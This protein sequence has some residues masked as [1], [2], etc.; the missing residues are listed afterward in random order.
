MRELLRYETRGILVSKTPVTLSD[1]VTL[2]LFDFKTEAWEDKPVLLFVA[3]WLSALSGWHEVLEEITPHYRV[4]YMESREKRSARLPKGPLPRFDIDRL[5]GDIGEVAAE[6]VPPGTPLYVAGSSLGSTA[7][8]RAMA[9][10]RLSPKGA[11]LISPVTAFAF[12]AWGNFIIRFLPPCFFTVI[13]YLI[14]WYL[15]NFRVDKK[16]EPEQARKYTRTVMDA[17]PIRLKANAGALNGYTLWADLPKVNTPVVVIGAASDK[18]HGVEEIT[19]M[20]TGMP[21]AR[22]EV[23]GSNKETH[24]GRAGRFIAEGMAPGFEEPAEARHP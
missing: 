9:R 5:A 7:L 21:H 16:K 3:G 13:R 24:S 12:P 8:I 10:G 2:T 23:M 17:E 11:F 19:K 15:V 4:I 18:L 22:V 1:G 20:A 14:V 6:L